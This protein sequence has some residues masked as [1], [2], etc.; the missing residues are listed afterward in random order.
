MDSP[1]LPRELEQKIFE[2]AAYSD[3][4]CVPRLVL[5][6]WR[7]KEW[8]EPFRYRILVLMGI[9]RPRLNGLGCFPHQDDHNFA[10][11][12]ATP[13]SIFKK[14]VR[15]MCLHYVYD[16]VLEYIL[17]A[18]RDLENLWVAHDFTQTPL[19]SIFHPTRLK[20]LHCN[21]RGLFPQ[22]QK[23]DFTHPIF[24][25]LTHLDLFDIFSDWLL[26]GLPLILNLTHLAFHDKALVFQ[27]PRLLRECKVLRVVVYRILWE[28]FVA[29]EV[30][31][32]LDELWEDPRFVQMESNERIKDWHMGALTGV[33]FW[34]QADNFTR[35][36]R[37]GEIDLR[38]SVIEGD[39]SKDLP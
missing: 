28:G 13:P 7:V 16:P 19:A 8:V 1:I 25:H 6:A 30:H 31:P 22:G 21:I 20:Q 36:R 17:S 23:A 15:H 37:S 27:L 26:R 29:R 2:L 33:D 12:L 34:S 3:P 14:S 35:K 39:P 10:R 32:E 38:Q 24:A 18:A 9:I 11:I 5:V 4:L